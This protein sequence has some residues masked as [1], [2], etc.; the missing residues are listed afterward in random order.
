MSSRNATDEDFAQVI[1][2]LEAGQIDVAPWVTHRVA[3]EELPGAFPGWV[4]PGNQVVK[5]ML[6]L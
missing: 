5:A 6:E 2:R 4:A 3:P 1:G